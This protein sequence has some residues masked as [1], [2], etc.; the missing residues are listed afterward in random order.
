MFVKENMKE[1]IFVRNY[2]GD[3]YAD[4][5]NF[6]VEKNHMAKVAENFLEII[7]DVHHFQCGCVAVFEVS[8]NNE[9]G[10]FLFKLIRIPGQDGLTGISYIVTGPLAEEYGVLGVRF[11]MS[12]DYK[13]TFGVFPESIYI[14]GIHPGI[15]E[16]NPFYSRRGPIDPEDDE[17]VLGREIDIKST[18]VRNQYVRGIV[19]SISEAY[20]HRKFNDEADRLICLGW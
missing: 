9:T 8:E 4:I 3:W 15:R 13:D 19:Q 1:L 10:S 12:P 5:P 16:H 14:H 2:R 11:W 20:D 17:M 6:P 18:A 7:T